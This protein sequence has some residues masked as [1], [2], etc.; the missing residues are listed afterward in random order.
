[1]TFEIEVVVNGGLDGG[2]EEAT[3]RRVSPQV[4]VFLTEPSKA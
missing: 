3:K 1:M 4:E 2:S